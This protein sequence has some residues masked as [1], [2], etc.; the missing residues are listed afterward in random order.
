MDKGDLLQVTVAVLSAARAGT[1]ADE[2][3]RGLK[4]VLNFQR[5]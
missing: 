2:T 4:P 3:A 5:K 1:Y